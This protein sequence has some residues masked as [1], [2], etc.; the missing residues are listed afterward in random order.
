M[1]ADTG[2]Q[3]HA[4]DNG[5]RVKT[6]HLGI[7]VQFIEETDPQSKVGIGKKFH[8][9]R[10]RGSHEQHRHILLDGAFLDDGREGVSGL[11]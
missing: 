9:L 6:L 2:I 1:C 7:S 8:S 11:R 10:L 5:L 3:S 4:L